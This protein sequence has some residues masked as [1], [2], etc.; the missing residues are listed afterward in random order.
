MIK[1]S[2]IVPVYNVSTYL[3]ECM[4]SIIGQTYKNL[5]IIC[6][7][8]GST[9]KSLEVLKTKYSNINKVSIYT[10]NNQGLSS[11]RNNGVRLARGKYIYFID[12][13]DLLEDNALETMYN[14]LDTN[15]LDILFFDAESFFED[16]DKS[17]MD[18]YYARKNEYSDIYSGIDLMKSMSEN[19]EYRASACLQIFNREFYIENNLQFINGILHE[20]NAFTFNCLREE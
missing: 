5:E 12:S 7:N 10:Q 19:G 3:S 13:D 2:V 6:I 20:D 17:D 14:K 18:S 1:F 16:C 9:D 15:K 4:E 8:D 11:T